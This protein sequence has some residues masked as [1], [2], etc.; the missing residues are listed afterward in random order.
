[1]TV[2]LCTCGLV[3]DTLVIC[4]RARRLY[5]SGYLPQPAKQSGSPSAFNSPNQGHANRTEA[6]AKRMAALRQRRRSQGLVQ[7]TVWVRPPDVDEI[8]GYAEALNAD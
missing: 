6:A 2:K 8:K 1:M 5:E 3:H 4:S 7:V